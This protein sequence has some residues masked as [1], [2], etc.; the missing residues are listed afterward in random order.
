M[1]HVQ[2]AIIHGIAVAV[3]IRQLHFCLSADSGRHLCV[4]RK[5]GEQLVQTIIQH[6]LIL[7]HQVVNQSKYKM[8]DFNRHPLL[9]LKSHN[10]NITANCYCGMCQNCTT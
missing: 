3:L 5:V 10:D 8:R 9:D 2:L 1:R 6:I 7:V 4:V